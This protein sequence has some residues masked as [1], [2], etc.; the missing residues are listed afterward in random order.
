MSG[1]VAS[2]AGV[3][4]CFDAHG[5]PITVS[6][7]NLPDLGQRPLYLRRLPHRVPDGWCLAHNHV[8]PAARH[9]RQPCVAATARQAACRV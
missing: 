2:K 9:P 8:I 4:E 7:D 6:C 1:D 5:N 3:V